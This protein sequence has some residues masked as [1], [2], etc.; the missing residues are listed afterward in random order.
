MEQL[1][2]VCSDGV[3]RGEGT[4]SVSPSLPPRRSFSGSGR[5]RTMESFSDLWNV[6]SAVAAGA[7]VGRGA[8]A[9]LLDWI[10]LWSSCSRREWELHG[11]GSFTEWVS[12]TRIARSVAEEGRRRFEGEPA[13]LDF[14]Q[15]HVDGRSGVS[16]FSDRHGWLC[17]ERVCVDEL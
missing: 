2:G 3:Y 13:E 9:S 6:S 15:Q 4:P 17:A 7:T 11:R 12:S 5:C 16:F 1:A 8:D 10:W 14:L